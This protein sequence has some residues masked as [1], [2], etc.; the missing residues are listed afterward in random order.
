MCFI[1][2]FLSE[3]LTIVCGSLRLRGTPFDKHCLSLQVFSYDRCRNTE[4]PELVPPPPS[5]FTSVVVP[6]LFFVSRRS[7]CVDLAFNKNEYQE[8]SLESKD[9]RC[10]GLTTLPPSCADCLKIIGVLTSWSPNRPYGRVMGNLYL[11]LS[12][13]H[14][15]TCSLMYWLHH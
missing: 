15:K 14:P 1:S 2:V 8:S 9:G 5:V 7:S 13:C 12:S 10:I 11:Y 6:T 3:T 4:H